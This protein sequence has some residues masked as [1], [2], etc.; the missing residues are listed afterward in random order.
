VITVTELG[1]LMRNLGQ[2]PTDDDLQEVCY[3]FSL[4]ALLSY[5]AAAARW[6]MRSMGTEMG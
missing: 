4:C 1:D 6:S 3:S 5:W 2:V